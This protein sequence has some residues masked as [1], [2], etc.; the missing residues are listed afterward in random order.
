MGREERCMQ[1]WNPTCPIPRAL[2]MITHMNVFPQLKLFGRARG[3]TSSSSTPLASLATLR[4]V[5]CR[6]N[7]ESNR[8]GGSAASSP[9]VLMPSVEQIWSVGGYHDEGSMQVLCGWAA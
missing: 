5:P 8:E 2:A 9:T 4:P 7:F 6:G 1:R 3:L